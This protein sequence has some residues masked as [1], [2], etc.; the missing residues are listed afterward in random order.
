MIKYLLEG[1]ELCLGVGCWFEGHGPVAV[2]DE[3]LPH[4]ALHRGVL[5]RVAANPPHSKHRPQS[6]LGTQSRYGVTIHI[7]IW[8]RGLIWGHNLH[9]YHG[10]RS[11]IWDTIDCAGR[12]THHIQIRGHGQIYGDNSHP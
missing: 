2:G 8:G 5:R 9:S 12:L 6:E 1:L 10:P 4:R 3:L 11:D 7:Q